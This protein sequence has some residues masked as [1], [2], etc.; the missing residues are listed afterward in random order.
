[1]FVDLEFRRLLLTQDRMDDVL[2]DILLGMF[3]NSLIIR[4]NFDVSLHEVHHGPPPISA[5]PC[6]D[7]ARSM[8]GGSIR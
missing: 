8:I 4:F 1:V 7:V 6:D 3:N 2:V 5:P